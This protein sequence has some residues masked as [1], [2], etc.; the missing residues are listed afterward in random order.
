LSLREFWTWKPPRPPSKAK[1]IMVP[2]KGADRSRCPPSL[3]IKALQL[4]NYYSDGSPTVT[5]SSLGTGEV[6]C[7]AGGAAPC[8]ALH[9]KAARAIRP[10]GVQKKKA[11]KR[12]LRKKRSPG[13]VACCRGFLAQA[14]ICGGGRPPT[15]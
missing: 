9:A 1:S 4:P 8:D 2:G 11:G 10:N 15:P 6:P 5:G 12:K 3:I 14:P 13:E 7:C